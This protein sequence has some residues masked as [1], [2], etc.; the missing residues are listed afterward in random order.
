[1]F[2]SQ[3]EGKLG[4]E[5]ALDMHVQLGFRQPSDELGHRRFHERL[6]CT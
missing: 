3:L 2:G 6:G 4:L 1:M 5:R